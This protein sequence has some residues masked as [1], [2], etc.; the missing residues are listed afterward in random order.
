[1][2]DAD[3]RVKYR[4]AFEMSIIEHR[5]QENFQKCTSSV[6]DICTERLFKSVNWK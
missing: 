5:G 6:V 2:L 3:V 4:D 1:M